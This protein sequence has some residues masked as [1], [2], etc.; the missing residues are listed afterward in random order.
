MTKMDEV[1][2]EFPEG[3]EPLG[4]S[5]FQFRCGPD[6]EC[7]MSCCRKLELILYPYDII[8]LKNRLGISSEEFMR[9]HTML[10][11]SSHP[12]F[13]SV[14]LLMSDNEEHTCPFLDKPGC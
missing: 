4:K 6:V 14:M 7:Y 5:V 3:L 12:F 8:R 11:P 1:K 9:R 13:P 10:G 2:K